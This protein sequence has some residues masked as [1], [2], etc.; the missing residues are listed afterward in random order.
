M[1]T[2]TSELTGAGNIL[3]FMHIEHCR[4]SHTCQTQKSKS[5]K[6][7]V[8]FGQ[9]SEGVSFDQ[10][11]HPLHS[12]AEKIKYKRKYIKYNIMYINI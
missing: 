5:W 4:H 10:F 2:P 1:L 3:K 11:P 6:R 9:P 7:D 8:F 12:R